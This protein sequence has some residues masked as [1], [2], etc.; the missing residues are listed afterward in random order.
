MIDVG[1]HC[2]DCG[3]SV[4]LGSGSY[5]NRIPADNGEKEGWMCADCQAIECDVCDEK[6]L[7]WNFEDDGL[8]YC[9]DCLE[10][11]P[12]Y[13]QALIDAQTMMEFSDQLEPTSAL[14]QAGSDNKIPYGD[15]MGRFVRWANLQTR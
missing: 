10:L 3:C 6:T 5:V 2:I 15:Q 4:A 9:E 14:K 12:R 11:L 1:E 8:C 13:R 7:D